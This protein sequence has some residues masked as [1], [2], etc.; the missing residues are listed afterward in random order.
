M[1]AYPLIKLA[2][3]LLV[4]IGAGAV[5]SNAIK[6]STPENAKAIQKIAI[7]VGGF[8][9]SGMAGEMAVKY[10]DQNIDNAV[11]QFKAAK[12]KVKKKLP[13]ADETK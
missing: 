2:A 10:T 6:V 5:V 8:V 13:P 12:D 3:D 1:N 11:D 7:G 4:S 9:L